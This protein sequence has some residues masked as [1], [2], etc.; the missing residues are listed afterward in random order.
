LNNQRG[1][2][3]AHF[4]LP[5]PKFSCRILPEARARLFD[6]MAHY[7]GDKAPVGAFISQ[8]ILKAPPKLWKEVRESMDVRY[9]DWR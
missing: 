9:D 1:S 8:L 4:S 6:E 5:N 2:P 3:A 7:R